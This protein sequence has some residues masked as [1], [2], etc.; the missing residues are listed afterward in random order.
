M[1]RQRIQAATAIQAAFKRYQTQKAYRQIQE[2]E[3]RCLALKF[4]P[5]DFEQVKE[6]E[7]RSNST[8]G[9]FNQSIQMEKCGL[10]KIFVKYLQPSIDHEVE[11]DVF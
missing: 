8:S 1:R 11:V 3:R 7:I 6:V 2:K 10:R 5:Q 4:N 9:P